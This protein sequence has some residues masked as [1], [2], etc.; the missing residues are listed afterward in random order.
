MLNRWAAVLP[1]GMRRRAGV[2]EL[3]RD[4]RVD[5]QRIC[6]ADQGDLVLIFLVLTIG[7]TAERD[8][9]VVIARISAKKVGFGL[10]DNRH[11]GEFAFLLDIRGNDPFLELKSIG[12]PIAATGIPRQTIS[13]KKK[14]RRVSELV[15]L[16]QVEETHLRAGSDGPNGLVIRA[17][18]L[19][20][21]PPTA[22]RR[23][24][25]GD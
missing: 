15:R 11:I 4:A 19:A 7:R 17:R 21:T 2:H 8:P 1:S 9:H 25:K 6:R 22:E 13:A 16:E 24:R 18:C 20:E 14:D 12:K 3:N 23:Q 10:I 5:D